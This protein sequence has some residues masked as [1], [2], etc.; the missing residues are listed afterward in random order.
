DCILRIPFDLFTVSAV[1]TT[2]CDIHLTSTHREAEAGQTVTLVCKV[3]MGGCVNRLT[4]F[5]DKTKVSNVSI[6][7]DVISSTLKLVNVS[8]KD[9]GNYKCEEQR[10]NTDNMMCSRQLDVFARPYPIVQATYKRYV[11]QVYHTIIL[12]CLASD[13]YQ[14]MASVVWYHDNS[15]LSSHKEEFSSNDTMISQ[16]TI[17]NSTYDDAG[18]YRCRF[19][20]LGTVN[21]AKTILIVAQEGLPS[22]TLDKY[23]VS[24]DPGSTFTMTCTAKYPRY[25]IAEL[26]WLKDGSTSWSTHSHSRQ[27]VIS[28]NIQTIS[29]GVTIK[30]FSHDDVGNYTCIAMSAIRNKSMSLYVS[31]REG[32]YTPSSTSM[33]VW[34]VLVVVLVICSTLGLVT[35]FT[36]RYLRRKKVLGRQ[37]HGRVERFT[38]TFDNSD[39]IYES[40]LTYSSKD[41]EW[42]KTKLIPLLEKRS[43]KYCI[44]SRD[45]EVGKAL[46]ENITDSVYQ[47][48]TVIAVVSRNFMSSKKCRDELDIALYRIAER[49]D[50]SLI[51]IRVDTIEKNQ[52]PK[53]LRNRTF[54]DYADLEE[55]KHWEKRLLNHLF[56]DHETGHLLTTL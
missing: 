29:Y 23:E 8:S 21:E 5:K 48:R 20:L 56:R 37:S 27:S 7:T 40:F 39:Y 55:R 15:R 25:D 42:V 41:F 13:I 24:K 51:V 6:V 11:A 32:Q 46:I 33:D 26:Y 36:L 2:Q 16:L 34:E 30:H 14:E 17:T 3:K 10:N 22:V 4:W 18:Q 19:E 45:Y 52:L 9:S 43:V 47:S 53:A 54:L 44:A 31:V 28:G 50:G 12:Q 49:N 38:Y 35:A 1:Y